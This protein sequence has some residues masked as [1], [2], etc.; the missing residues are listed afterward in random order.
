MAETKLEDLSIRDL[1]AR[2][3]DINL[4]RDEIVRLIQEAASAIGLAGAKAAPPSAAPPARPATAPG[5]TAPI[6]QFASTISELALHGRQDRR[7]KKG[8]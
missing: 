1:T 6:A 2:L 8:T 3:A 4:E 7:S 5:R